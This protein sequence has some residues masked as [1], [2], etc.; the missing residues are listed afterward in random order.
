VVAAGDGRRQAER[1]LS[2]ALA[3]AAGGDRSEVAAG[4]IFLFF[5]PF[6]LKF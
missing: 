2:V 5:N 1:L 3:R 6:N 4:G